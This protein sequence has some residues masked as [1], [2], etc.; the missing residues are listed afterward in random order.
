MKVA[1]LGYGKMG[2]EIEKISL[3]RGHE[4]IYK[5]DKESQVKNIYDAD[6]AINF[7]TP[8]T[9]VQNITLGLKSSVPVVSGTTGWLS[10]LNKIKEL[11]QE[12]NT[13]FLYSSNFSLG[14]NLFF[15]LNNKLAVIM[16][17]YNQYDLKIEEIHHTQKIDKPSGTAISLAEDII[18]NG[19]YD[20]WTM[21]DKKNTIKI[22][23]KRI[24]KVPGTHIVNYF[25]EIDSIE[26]KHTANN[27]K[28][29]ALGAVLAAEWI[30]NKKGIFKKLQNR[31][32]AIGRM[33]FTNYIGM[34]LICTLI[35]NGHGLGLFGT[36][37]RLQQFL[38]VIG[39]WVIMLIISPL[40]LKKYQFGPLESMWRKLTYFSF[41]NS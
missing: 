11:S 15:E 24:D 21:D 26:I 12:K 22:D 20:R 23:S 8:E 10:D 27:R 31:L 5:I 13:S 35:F 17:K 30:I 40:V 1:I 9:A 2:K 32:Q 29:F 33:A 41:K 39:L 7:S 28:G 38:I 3:L 16:K 18:Q 4:L 34:S 37:D 36:F 14:V 6:V 25:S 19:N